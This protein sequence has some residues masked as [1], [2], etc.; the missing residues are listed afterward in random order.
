MALNIR[1]KHCLFIVAQSVPLEK[2]QQLMGLFWTLAL[3]VI[4]LFLFVGV[5]MALVRVIRRRARLNE[6]A[7]SNRSKSDLLNPWDESAKRLQ[8][9]TEKNEE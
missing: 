9:H 2:Q 1:P 5:M 3:A 8:S 6:L 4:L 7:Q